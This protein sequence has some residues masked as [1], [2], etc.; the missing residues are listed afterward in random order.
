MDAVVFAHDVNRSAGLP[1]QTFKDGDLEKPGW[2]G[3][4]Q[5]ETVEWGPG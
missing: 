3:H 5:V 2:E 4:D 1:L